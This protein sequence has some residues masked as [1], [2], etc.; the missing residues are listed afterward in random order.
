MQRYGCMAVRTLSDF[1]CMREA[2]METVTEA[3]TEAMREALRRRWCSA[4]CAALMHYTYQ[5]IA[6]SEVCA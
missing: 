2:V 6:Y 1:A 3:V 4:R 5:C